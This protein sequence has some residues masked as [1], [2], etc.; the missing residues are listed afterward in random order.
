MLHRLNYL[1]TTIT[2]PISVAK[3]QQAANILAP[4]YFEVSI[5]TDS[6]LINFLSALVIQFLLLDDNDEAYW[7]KIL[8]S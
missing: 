2:D 5:Y 1:C 8:P 4:I 6:D 3:T 7:S